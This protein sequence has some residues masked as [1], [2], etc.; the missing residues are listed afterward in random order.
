[1]LFIV[2]LDLNKL[3]LRIYPRAG[4]QMNRISTES[5]EK[6]YESIC[7]LTE[8]EAYRLSFDFQKDQPLVVAYLTAVDQDI[9]NQEERELLFYLGAVAW[10]IMYSGNYN[11]LEANQ[12]L[13]LNIEAANQKTADSLR[14]TDSVKFA[15]VVKILLKEC[16]Q[17]DVLRYV[18]AALMD[19]NDAENSIRDE[20]LGIIILDLKTVID[21]LDR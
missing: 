13:L 18:I 10:K 6:A 20:N 5:V 7:N 2:F 19:K 4:D 1:M 21:Y 11:H 9:I 14:T 16:R 3:K 17:T 15:E 8:P 12:D